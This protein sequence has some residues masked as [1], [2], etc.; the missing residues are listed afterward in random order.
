MADA[1]RVVGG[2][3][4][5]V[6]SNCLGLSAELNLIRPIPVRLG[7]L[8]ILHNADQEHPAAAH[9]H[10]LDRLSRP[11]TS[12]QNAQLRHDARPLPCLILRPPTY[13]PHAFEDAIASHRPA[14]QPPSSTPH[15]RPLSGRTT[16][17][18]RQTANLG[19]EEGM[20]PDGGK[21]N[22]FEL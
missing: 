17:S 3:G 10:S 22:V 18:R 5:V 2:V 8:A 1:R 7:V 19:E 20:T 16:I 9:G 21:T 12:L 15:S 14:H 13:F 6:R 4:V 11:L